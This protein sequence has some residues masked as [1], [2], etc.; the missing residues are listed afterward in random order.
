MNINDFPSIT[1]SYFDTT[2]N[3]IDEFLR[4]L[5]KE[6]IEKNKTIISRV[7][8]NDF[9]ALSECC[10]KAQQSYSVSSYE[11]LFYNLSI[12]NDKTI[13]ISNFNRWLVYAM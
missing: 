13:M 3:K 6:K 2:I 7:K 12:C 1:F 11:A 4:V 8:S 5:F 9:N 10:L